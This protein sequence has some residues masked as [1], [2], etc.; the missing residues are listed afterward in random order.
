MGADRAHAAPPRQA[1]ALHQDPAVCALR[2]PPRDAARRRRRRRGQDDFARAATANVHR[3]RAEGDCGSSS[4]T[5]REH[6]SERGA[7]GGPHGGR[8]ALRAVARP[9]RRP[10]AAEGPCAARPCAL[11][12]RATAAS[13]PRPRRSGRRRCRRAPSRAQVWREA[14][15]HRSSWWLLDR[16]GIERR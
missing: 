11:A 13:T 3:S 8:G 12:A 10:G 7:H 6:C 1:L 5:L 14:Q 2:T 16:V 15:P 4:K 9:Q